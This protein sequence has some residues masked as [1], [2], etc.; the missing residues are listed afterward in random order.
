VKALYVGINGVWNGR[1]NLKRKKGHGS[2]KPS[3]R[4]ANDGNV[5]NGHGSNACLRLLEHFSKPEQ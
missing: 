5:S 3:E 2:S 4:N 1:P